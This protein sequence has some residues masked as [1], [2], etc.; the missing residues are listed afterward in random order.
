MVTEMREMALSSRDIERSKMD[1]Q[2]KLFSKQMD[3]QQQKDWNLQKTSKTANENVKLSILKQ[4]EI[5]QCLLHLAAI[6]SVGSQLSTS[7]H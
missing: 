6:L 1:I 3:Y 5:V 7:T 2:L 4:G